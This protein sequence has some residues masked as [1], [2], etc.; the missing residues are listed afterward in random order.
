MN[1]INHVGYV[2]KNDETGKFVAPL[3]RPRSYVSNIL[4]A[5]YFSSREKAEYERCGNETIV[6]L[7]PRQHI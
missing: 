7:T 3:G 1:I 2:L 4:D 5:R 6:L